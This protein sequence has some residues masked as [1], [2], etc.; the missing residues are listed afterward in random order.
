MGQAEKERQ[1]SAQDSDILIVKVDGTS[2]LSN[3]WAPC[4]YRGLEH[5]HA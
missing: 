2:Y 5:P 3:S 1:V 4:P